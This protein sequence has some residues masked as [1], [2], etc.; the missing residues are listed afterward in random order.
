MEDENILGAVQGE[1]FVGLIRKKSLK[2][3]YRSKGD[4]FIKSGY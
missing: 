4:I 2:E 3:E 1:Y